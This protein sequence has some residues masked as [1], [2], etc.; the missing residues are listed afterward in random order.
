M[1]R[2]FVTGSTGLL[3]HTV[4]HQLLGQGHEVSALVRSVEKGLRVLPPAA[5]LVQGDMEQVESFA[6]ALEGHDAVIHTAAYFREYD[7]DD[8]HRAALW[9]INVDGTLGLAR[10]A[11]RFGVRRFV[12]ISSAGIIG[13]KPD[14]SAGDET[15]PPHPVSDH[16]LYFSSKRASEEA[17][18][19]LATELRME[20]IFLLPGMMLGPG[21]EGP[22]TGGAFVRNYL[23]GLAFVFPEG[24]I[25]VV[26]VR[27]V[28]LAACAALSRGVPGERYIVCGK[29]VDTRQLG[30]SLARL[31]GGRPPLIVPTWAGL[32]IAWCAELY[33]RVTRTSPVITRM[34]VRTL[35]ARLDVS[36]ER[37]IAALGFQASELDEAIRD[38]IKWFSEQAGR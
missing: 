30:A 21:D 32:F 15:T 37:A 7:G 24:G 2:I 28:A 27:D 10:A 1:G 16:N 12:D 9:R 19:A 34:T 17:L 13:R 5:H 29:Y 8:E 3:G 33:A 35:E 31:S 20:M 14:G 11:S 26:H 36:S 23:R 25:G 22:T 4:V 38:T 18:R 6:A